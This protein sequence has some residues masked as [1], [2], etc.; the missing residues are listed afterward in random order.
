MVRK[1]LLSLALLG[2]TALPADAADANLLTQGLEALS[3]HQYAQAVTRLE[4]YTR[5]QPEDLKALQG[6]AR[7]YL[8]LNQAE[9]ADATLNAAQALDRSSA[10][11]HLLR[12]RLRLMQQDYLR[13]RSEFRTVIYLQ[14][15]DA[16]LWYY[17]S[18]VYQQLG[19]TAEADAA[20]A[21]GLESAA[22][23]ADIQA[24][25]LLLQA[26]QQP[27]QTEALL[28]KALALSELSP[29]L[30]SELKDRLAS[31]MIDT[32][33]L[34]ELIQ[35][36]MQLLEGALA[37]KTQAQRILSQTE[38]WLG[39]SKQADADWDFYLKQLEDLNERHPDPL[40]H[41]QLVRLYQRQGL[42]ERLQALYQSDLI[43]GAGKLSETEL[44]AAY[45]RLADVF[46]KQ[47]FLDFAFNNYERATN[48]NTHDLEGLKRMGVIY[49]VAQKPNDAIKMFERVQQELPQDRE[50]LM[51]LSLAHALMYHDDDARRLLNLVPASTRPDIRSRVEAL[52]ASPERQADMRLWQLLIPDERI[53]T[54]S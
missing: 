43:D 30:R 17:L 40:L 33:R 20:V 34:E 5:L 47:G 18:Q 36:Q 45:H 51:F 54:D 24:R 42:Y 4:Q 2:A 10:Q 15:T 9:L 49:M 53:L 48:L 8:E 44:A 6:L 37:S 32:G 21:K 35:S 12:G 25:L 41:Q 7:A 11:T 16:E 26:K 13:A 14:A 50:N 28:N 1:A 46:L 39:Q 38:T 31:L 27:D 29:E 19:E 3:Q 23:D 22:G 52:L